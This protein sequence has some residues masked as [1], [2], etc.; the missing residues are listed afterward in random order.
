MFCVTK[1]SLLPFFLPGRKKIFLTTAIFRG[2]EHFFKDNFSA[3]MHQFLHVVPHLKGSDYDQVKSDLSG[4]RWFSAPS[5]QAAEQRSVPKAET[6]LWMPAAEIHTG[7]QFW[8]E[9]DAR[10]FHLHTSLHGGFFMCSH[11]LGSLLV[12]P[13]VHVTVKDTQRQSCYTA[14]NFTADLKLYL[15]AKPPLYIHPNWNANSRNVWSSL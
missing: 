12:H 11:I 5:D 7:V 15:S 1:T 3:Q 10:Y 9:L 14:S 6:S 13:P 4:W 8:T 2:L